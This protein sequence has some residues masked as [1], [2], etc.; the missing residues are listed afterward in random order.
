MNSDE[1][2]LRAIDLARKKMLAG[3]GRPFGCVILKD[4]EVIGEGWNCMDPQP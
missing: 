3:E 4:G 1:A 2:M